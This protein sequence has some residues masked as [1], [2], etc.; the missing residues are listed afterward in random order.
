MAFMNLA[1]WLVLLSCRCFTRTRSH[2]SPDDGSV[3]L[4]V[5]NCGE[6]H[7]LL[8]VT[9]LVPCSCCRSHPLQT[10]WDREFTGMC[11]WN[12]HLTGREEGRK[13][14]L[15]QGRSWAA[16]Q[17]EP[18]PWLT[19]GSCGARKALQSHPELGEEEEQLKSPPL[20]SCWRQDGPEKRIPFGRMALFASF[21]IC[22]VLKFSHPKVDSAILFSSF[23]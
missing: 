20:A 10:D 7:T 1:T 11:S 9:E 6:R 15:A 16:R 21:P 2:P 12:Q 13:V 18:W 17:L 3:A 8:S 5:L 23:F 19:L 22:Q 14:G 4:T